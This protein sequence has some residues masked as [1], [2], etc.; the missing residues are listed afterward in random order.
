MIA[1]YIEPSSTVLA[2]LVETALVSIALTAYVFGA[3]VP[4]VPVVEEVVVDVV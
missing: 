4:V 2:L 3:V 1:L